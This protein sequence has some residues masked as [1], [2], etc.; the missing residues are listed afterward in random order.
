MS[1]KKKVYICFEYTPDKALKDLLVGQS[2]N[3]DSP[4]EITDGSLKEAAPEKNWEQKA[5]ER[6]QSADTVLVVLGPTTHR[7]SGV[8]K[9][10]KIASGLN[11]KIV[12]LIGYKDSKYKRIPG[13]G[14]LY[15]WTWDNLKKILT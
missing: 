5:R 7:A 15:S 10:I 12:Q 3:H 9:E 1:R 11:K 6:I 13:A 2:K 4:F 14:R 8:L